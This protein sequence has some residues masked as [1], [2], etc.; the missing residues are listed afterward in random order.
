MS[1][2]KTEE[3]KSDAVEDAFRLVNKSRQMNPNNVMNDKLNDFEV[4]LWAFYFSCFHDFEITNS[5]SN[6]KLISFLHSNTFFYG[7]WL[8]TH[9][10]QSPSHTRPSPYYKPSKKLIVEAKL[11]INDCAERYDDEEDTLIDEDREA[12][13][14]AVGEA[15]AF[16]SDLNYDVQ[17][18]E[19]EMDDKTVELVK[20]LEVQLDQLKTELDAVLGETK[21]GNVLLGLDNIM[22]KIMNW[23]SW[24]KVSM[25]QKEVT[26][27]YSLQIYIHQICKVV[28]LY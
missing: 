2:L 1:S 7:H 20:T 12:A 18:G 6:N 27:T 10:Y 14:D 17:K 24:K 4:G 16:F 28:P 11:S 19:K 3:T 15:I 22:N 8:S 26:K 25:V 21:R 23:R 13:K 9:L 5:L